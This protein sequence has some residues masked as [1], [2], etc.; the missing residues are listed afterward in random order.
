MAKNPYGRDYRLVESFSEKGRVKT[1]YEYIGEPCFFRAGEETARKKAFQCTLLTA[2]AWICYIGAMF[3]ESAAMHRLYVAL[4]F[5]F[6]GVPLTLLTGHMMALR[7]M[8][9]PL[10]RRHMDRMNNKFPPAAMFLTLFALFALAGEGIGLAV[11]AFSGNAGQLFSGEIVFL[12][13]CTGL[14]LCGARLFMAR[15][16]FVIIRRD[17]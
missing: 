9:E 13:G 16:H 4:P 2:A 8:R 3:F 6:C 12:I 15:T 11:S 17:A 7:G 1:S 5:A 14:V 10:E